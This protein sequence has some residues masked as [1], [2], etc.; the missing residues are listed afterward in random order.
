MSL[1][2]ALGLVSM[3][4]T[5]FGTVWRLKAEQG[6]L[7]QD[8]ETRLTKIET[9]ISWVVNQTR[10]RHKIL[11]NYYMDENRNRKKEDADDE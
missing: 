9:D 4:A 6:K 3:V 7:R 10:E 5:F 8:V 1:G 2:T 11:Q